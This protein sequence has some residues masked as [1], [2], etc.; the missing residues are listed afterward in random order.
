MAGGRAASTPSNW[1][2]RRAVR[3][4][5]LDKFA[6]KPTLTPILSPLF[7]EAKANGARLKSGASRGQTPT[8]ALNALECSVARVRVFRLAAG[9]GSPTIRGQ[10]ELQTVSRN[11]PPESRLD[12]TVLSTVPLFDESEVKGY[13]HAC[14]PHERLQHLEILR[15]MNYGHKAAA[16]LQ[17]VLE[18]TRVS[19]G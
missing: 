16:R 4:A 8:S 2:V 9:G 13:W 17:R 1:E 15:Q 19:W 7:F 12:R 5:S 3:Q 10:R 6:K 11:D 14:T 18:T